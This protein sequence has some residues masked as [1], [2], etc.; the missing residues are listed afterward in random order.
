[1]NDIEILEKLIERFDSPSGGHII[2]TELSFDE[3]N[4]IENLIKRNKEL[5][6]YKGK[7]YLRIL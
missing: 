5:D 6:C 7:L 2:P 4:A 1:M 3:R